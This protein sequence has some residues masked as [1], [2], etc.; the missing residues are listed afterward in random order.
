[1]K[2]IFN[3][4]VYII[5][6]VVCLNEIGLTQWEWTT[7]GVSICTAYGDQWNPEILSDG[8]GGAIIT[9]QDSRSSGNWDIY[10]HRFVISRPTEFLGLAVSTTTIIWSWIDNSPNEDGFYIFTS[11]GGIVGTVSTNTTY[12]IE[13]NLSPNTQYV[14]YIRAYN[15]IGF[16]DPSNL[17][18][19]YTLAKSP[20]GL[21]AVGVYLSSVTLRWDD[22]GATR[23]AIERST[24]IDEPVNWQ[25]VATWA[26]NIVNPVFIDTNLSQ[27]TQYW[28]RI[29]SYNADGV[30]N[31]NPSNIIFVVTRRVIP[32]PNQISI[33][34]P[35]GKS[36][37][38]SSD[39][40]IN[41]TAKSEPGTNIYS[42]TV[43]DQNGNILTKDIDVSNISV[44]KDGNIQGRIQIGE[45]TKN[46]PL[47]NSIIIEIVVTDKGGNLSL[48]S[49]AGPVKIAPAS[50]PK[51]TV[52][53]NL[54][55]PLKNEKMY[56][57]YEVPED[58]TLVEIAIYDF[59]SGKK[60]KNLYE[61][62]KSAGVYTDLY[63]NG[64]D[65][66][67]NIVPTGAYLI[68]TRRRNKIT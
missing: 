12:W 42:I 1:M 48:P 49:V 36:S 5:T 59:Y 9:W 30:I 22:V 23:Y 38:T 11:T 37:I 18:S 46:Y 25:Y 39:T 45:I 44:D 66:N 26:D 41:L 3:N 19:K 50:S 14:R 27:K 6:L 21:L 54:F 20:T 60:V 63:W 4:A 33:S 64:K 2:K 53:N 31:Q 34:L 57:R 24:G 61:G 43:K 32:S 55:D 51:A 62:R 17:N 35:S 28:Y 52:Y 56:I 13:T 65:D 16:S 29:K 40:F 10:A 7:D 8:L 67:G 58:N 47:V 15:T 68:Y